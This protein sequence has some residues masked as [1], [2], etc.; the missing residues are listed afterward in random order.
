MAVS[1]YAGFGYMADGIMDTSVV[2]A[3]RSVQ[4]R[5]VVSMSLCFRNTV[6]REMLSMPALRK[7]RHVMQ[8]PS[9]YPGVRVPV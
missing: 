5:G 6:A 4:I 9:S 3:D 2:P 7:S 1:E 8:T